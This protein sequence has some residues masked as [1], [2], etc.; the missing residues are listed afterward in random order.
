M[1]INLRLI[2]QFGRKK[3]GTKMENKTEQKPIVI[4]VNNK[5][6]E[7]KRAAVNFIVDHPEIAIGGLALFGYICYQKG[8]D[9]ATM[10]VMRLA[11]MM[12]AR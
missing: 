6:D 11:A 5:I 2:P 3:K 7:G 8:R 12:P 4:D 9:K 1:D 10:D